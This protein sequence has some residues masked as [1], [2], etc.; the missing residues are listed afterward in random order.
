MDPCSSPTIQ[1]PELLTPL[2]PSSLQEFFAMSKSK[3]STDKLTA[4]ADKLFDDIAGV[5]DASDAEQGSEEDFE[6]SAKTAATS[7]ALPSVLTP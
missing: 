7:V 4:M 2:K 3:T 1:I 5:V 6:S